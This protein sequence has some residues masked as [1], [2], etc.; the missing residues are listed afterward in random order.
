MQHDYGAD[1][2]PQA[3][4]LEDLQRRLAGGYD[5]V[6]APNSCTPSSHGAVVASV[7]STLPE[8]IRDLLT[9]ILAE[10][11]AAASRYVVWRRRDTCDTARVPPVTREQLVAALAAAMQL[12]DAEKMQLLGAQPPKDAPVRTA[13]TT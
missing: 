13:A 9:Q 4:T 2:H 11:D 5:L 8:S 3:L 10:S 7:E 6:V 1:R 12:S